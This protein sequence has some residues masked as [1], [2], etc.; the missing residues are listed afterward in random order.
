[1]DQFS[2]DKREEALNTL[3]NQYADPAR[4]SMTPFER[5]SAVIDRKLPDRVP[6]DFWAVDE[7]IEKL[8]RYLDVETEEEMLRLLGIDCRMVAPDYVGP[9]PEKRADGTFFDHWGTHRRLAS[10]EFSTYEEYAS[11]PLAEAQTQAD[12][13]AY[14]KWPK[15][16]YWDWDSVLPKIDALNQE[17]HYHVRYEVGGVFEFAWALYG[18]D[19]FLIDMVLKPEVPRAILNCFTDLYIE[20]VRNLLERVGDQLPMVYT[21]DDVAIQNGLLMSPAMWREFIL[22][23]HQRLNAVIKEYDTQI[24]YH[25]C[26]AVVPLIKPFVEEMGIDVL[27]PLQPRAAGMDMAMIKQ[28]FGG[29][30]AFHGGVDLQHTLPFGSEAEVQAEVQHLISTLGR[31]GGYIC[32]S[33]HY[34]QADVPVENIIALYTARRDNP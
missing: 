10:N 28:Q 33:A 18:L 20:N 9:P 12:V 4:G 31:G 6:F 32:T 11:Y 2:A 25:S 17:T 1:M 24:M 23:C 19:K 27:N 13:E 14:S 30:V 8:R 21:Y 5:V 3:K 22:P 16:E 15:S 34:I 26:G 7:T 29:Q